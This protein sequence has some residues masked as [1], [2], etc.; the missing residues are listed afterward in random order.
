MTAF[1]GIDVGT[2]ATKALVMD[3]QGKVLATATGPHDV[4][5]PRPGWSQQDPGQWWQATCQAV[6][7]ACR[8][9][10]VRPEAVKGI[11]LSGQMHGLVMLDGAGRP[12]RPAIIWNDQRTAQQA[13]EVEQAAR[14]G[15]GS[16]T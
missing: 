14:G 8:K 10:K 1:I 16:S 6:R 4:L 5:T 12:I 15:P 3:G 7:A 9:A 13:R 2:S 11:G